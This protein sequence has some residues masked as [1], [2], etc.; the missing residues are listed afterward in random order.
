MERKTRDSILK[1]RL[2]TYTYDKLSDQ[3]EEPL[4]DIEEAMKEY[5]DQEMLLFANWRDK[6]YF[7]P[8]SGIGNAEKWKLRDRYQKEGYINSM[9]TD[10]QLLTLYKDQQS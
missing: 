9:L 5:A 8:F 1:V 3:Y 2:D 10:H 4:K 7:K 6:Y